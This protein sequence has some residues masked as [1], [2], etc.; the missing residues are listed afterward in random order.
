MSPPEIDRRESLAR[1]QHDAAAAG[2]FLTLVSTLMF[3]IGFAEEVS[4][5][6]AGNGG[7]RFRYRRGFEVI[8]IKTTESVALNR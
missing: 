3:V 7:Y 4:E 1:T 6:A 2:T 8:E 5:A